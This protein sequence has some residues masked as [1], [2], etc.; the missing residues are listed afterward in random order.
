MPPTEG[1]NNLRGNR[2]QLWN[3]RKL[4]YLDVPTKNQNVNIE[5]KYIKLRWQN[6]I[7]S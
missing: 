5:H 3:T 1:V 6:E 4:Q 2:N 7:N